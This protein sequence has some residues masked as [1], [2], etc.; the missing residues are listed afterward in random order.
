[1]PSPYPPGS[2]KPEKRPSVIA[3][4]RRP[5]LW[6]VL[7]IVLGEALNVLLSSRGVSPFASEAV[8]RAVERAAEQ[9][10]DA[11]R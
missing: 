4:A 8:R 11:A 5:T 3:R 9:Q 1:M 7:G 2:L 6:V 10:D